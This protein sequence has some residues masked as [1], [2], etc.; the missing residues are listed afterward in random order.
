MAELNYEKD[1]RIDEDALDL[2]LL[3]QASLFMKYAKH[4][5]FTQKVVEET[6]QALDI[7]RAEVDKAIRENPEKFK[8]EKVTEGA[9]QSTILTDK[10]YQEAN[11]KHLEAQ[12]EKN[13]AGNA[14]QSMTMRKEM[15]EGMIKLLAQ[16][17]FAGPSVPHDL[18]KLKAEREKKTEANIGTRLR[19]Q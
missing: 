17:Y 16:S 12:Y 10:G 3:N 1:L 4:Y 15:L 18:S 5:A 7:K 19:R 14:V 9:I 8:I 6:R 2:E 13:M 11:Q